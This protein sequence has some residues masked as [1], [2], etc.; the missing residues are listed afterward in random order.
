[1]LLPRTRCA[2]LAAV[3]ALAFGGCG[4]DDEGGI[5]AFDAAALTELPTDQWVT[6]GGTLR[7]DRYSPLDEINTGNVQ[8]LKG[9]WVT[10]LRSGK[11]AKFSGEAQPIVHDGVIYV[12]TGADDVFAIDADTGAKIWDYEANLGS[13]IKTVCCGWT[14]RGVA[15]GDGR[16]YVGQ[17]DGKLVALDA[18]SGDPEWETQVERWQDG[19]TI[20]S[21]PLYYDGMVVTGI[22]GGEFGIRG[23]VTAYDAE[24]GE[25]KWRFHTIPGPGEKGHDTWPRDNDMWKRGGAPVWQTPAVDPEL[26]L[27]YFS[28][29]NTAPDFNGSER[30]GDNL[31]A[32]S[33]VALD[34]DSGQYRWHFQQVHHD[35]WDFD[36]PAPVVLFDI[37]IDGRKRKALAEAG[38]T[39]WVYLLDRTNGK[40]L[41]GIDER[42]VPQDRRQRTARTQ[43]YPKGDAFVPQSVPN[44]PRGYR[45]PNGGRIFTPF[46]KD[47]PI[48]AKPGTLGGNNWPP[49][50]FNPR[51]NLLYVCAADQTSIYKTSDA[52]YRPEQIR[53]GEQFLASEFT[54]PKG[55]KPRGTFTALDMRTNE[56]TWQKR[57][58]DSCYSGSVTTAGNLVFTGHN[59]G[60]LLAYDARNGRRLWKFQTGAGANAPPTVFERHGRQYVVFYAAGNTLA[61]SS[62]GDN[63]WLFALDGD[64]GPAAAEEDE[65]E[66][67]Q[68]GETAAELFST[69]CSAC[70]GPEG[71]GGHNGPSLQRAALSGNLDAVVRQIREGSG[72]MPPFGDKLTDAQIGALARYVTEEVAPRGG[73]APGNE[74]PGNK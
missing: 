67:A 28:T 71:E 58:N 12:I 5:P 20:T 29:G 3:A 45:A 59:D 74:Q 31:F 57:W 68:Q 13:Q 47:N 51:T 65:D 8:Q 18:E 32:D 69:N 56:I 61:G 27:L 62:H 37:E 70:H 10:H 50:S 55:E 38:K 36:A 60:N 4:D 25:E 66:A 41:I 52:D 73:G 14:S 22:S 33:I 48:V 17:L 34:A 40:P 19:Y 9:D 23:R 26:G 44:S 16:V 7:N 21:A 53:K 39:G 46:W 2:V 43:P 35:I 30:P 72:P 64:L 63:L 54:S 1:M 24:T 49:S 15:I 6:N 42:P 11:N